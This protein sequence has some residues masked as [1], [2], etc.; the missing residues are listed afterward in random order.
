M[1]PGRVVPLGGHHDWVTMRGTT[2][3]PGQVA[4]CC[5]SQLDGA[6]DQAPC[7]GGAASCALKLGGAAGWAL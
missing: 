2:I 3:S 5:A 7:S 4:S 1:F 6:A